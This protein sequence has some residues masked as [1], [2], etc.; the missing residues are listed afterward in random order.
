MRKH[1]GCSPREIDKTRGAQQGKTDCRFHLYPFSLH[2][3]IMPKRK[4]FSFDFVCSLWLSS[5]QR[6]LLKV[7]GLTP[8]KTSKFSRLNCMYPISNSW[9]EWEC[10]IKLC[11]KFTSWYLFSIYCQFKWEKCFPRH[12]CPIRG[13]SVV[14]ARVHLDTFN[15]LLNFAARC[16]LHLF[17]FSPLF[18]CDIKWPDSFNGPLNSATAR[19]CI[20]SSAHHSVTE[21]NS[22]QI[23]IKRSDL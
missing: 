17:D 16:S 8:S 12:L 5:S 6:C 11:I 15:A 7:T 3:Q 18:E 23:H 22:T 9:I 19:N 4:I 10:S 13:Q 21:D 2:P 14:V 20:S 1:Q